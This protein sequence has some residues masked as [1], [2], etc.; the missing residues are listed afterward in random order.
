MLSLLDRRYIIQK[1]LKTYNI[2][3]VLPFKIF[4][5]SVVPPLDGKQKC[6]LCQ[7]MTIKKYK[8]IFLKISAKIER[9]KF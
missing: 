3:P 5:P 6:N 9:H 1:P 8:L 4:L 7:K 2:W